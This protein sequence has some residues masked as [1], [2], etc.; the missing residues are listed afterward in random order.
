MRSGGSGICCGTGW[1]ALA[2]KVA[3]M[4]C[5]NFGPSNSVGEAARR[6]SARF[7]ARLVSS[8]S[9]RFLFF[10]MCVQIV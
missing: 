10:A 1:E 8:G 3:S 2:L 6:I 7:R 5:F 4:A 9:S